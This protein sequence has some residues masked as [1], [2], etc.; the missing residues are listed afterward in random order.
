MCSLTHRRGTNYILAGDFIG[1]PHFLIVEKE[2]N[3]FSLSASEFRVSTT[4][5]P[6][7]QIKNR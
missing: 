1:G 3:C 2:S 6:E 5:V 4:T 7:L